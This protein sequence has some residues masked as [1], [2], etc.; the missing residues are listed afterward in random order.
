[1]TKPGVVYPPCPLPSR[2][3]RSKKEDVGAEVGHTVDLS[4]ART[5][6]GSPD[7]ESTVLSAAPH[8]W[9][10]RSLI[11]SSHRGGR[12]AR[13]PLKGGDSPDGLLPHSGPSQGPGGP[14]S[15]SGLKLIF[16]LEK[17]LEPGAGSVGG[18]RL[19]ALT[20]GAPWEQGG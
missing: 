2:C 17:V 3:G 10:I 14:G 1:M 12:A 18:W 11:S 16:L 19:S 15:R 8:L 4:R 13:S 9:A 20:R 6:A 5:S 7:S